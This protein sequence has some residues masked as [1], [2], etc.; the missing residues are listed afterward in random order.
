MASQILVDDLTLLR[1]TAHIF[2][3]SGL[4]L[5][6]LIQANLAS[7]QTVVPLLF[8]ENRDE[9]GQLIPIPEHFTGIFHAIEKDLGIQFQFQIYPWNRAVKIAS[10]DGGLIFGLSITPEREKIFTFSQPVM[11]NYL[12]LVTR[13][14]STF[15]FRT[16]D[17]LKGKTIGILRGS[18]YGGEF[19]KQKNVLFKADEDIDAYGSRLSKVLG[20]RI[21]AM[22]YASSLTNPRE[23]EDRVN[24]IIV[25][26]E[27]TSK[28]A[29]QKRFAVL[30]IPVL[31]DGIHFASLTGQ[32]ESLIQGINKSLT[33][34]KNTKQAK[35]TPLRT[36]NS[37]Q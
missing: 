1:R 26:N 23:V 24:K 9:K 19:D 5:F 21:D 37:M 12:W 30:P 36:S 35:K 29:T 32:N 33:R 14:D 28:M 2:F 8:A 11:Y 4:L 31:K 22:I 27:P 6:G 34:L 3:L 20:H 13:S 17:D 10:S 16:L 18:K 25:S 15:S 7:A